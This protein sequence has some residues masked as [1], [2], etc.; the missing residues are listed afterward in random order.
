MKTA[1]GMDVHAKFCSAY[2]VYAGMGETRERHEKFLD[3]FNKE[4]WKFPADG[5]GMKKMAAFLSKHECH[6]L[7][8]NSTKSHEIYWMLKGLGMNVTVAQAVDL[9][10]ITRSVKKTDRNDSIELAAYM[11][12]RL[13]GENEFAACF[14]PSPEWM[15]KRE[16]CRGVYN[17]R[18]YLKEARQRIRAHLLLHG[19]SLSKEYDD[20]LSVKAVREMQEHKDPYLLMQIK[21]ALDAKSRVRFV[22]KAIAQMFSGNRM[23]ELILSIPGVGIVPAAYLTSLIVDIGRFGKVTQFTASFGVVPGKR[24]SADH[25]P[26]CPTT[27]RGDEV[28][29][30]M[31][32]RCAFSHIQNVEDSVVTEMYRRL[33]KRGKVKNEALT[34]ASRKLL[35]VIWSV[36]KKNAPYTVDPE[37]LKRARETEDAE[38][39]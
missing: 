29:R 10:R 16:M 2:A 20:I 6:V 1:I 38:E 9:Y 34:A 19:I 4:F 3:S 36:L 28:A 7:I 25:S 18:I 33:V 27:H 22:E 5:D 32:K 37:L 11:R 12:R 13:N 15:T 21:F 14:I 24:D 17:E 23:Y 30:V 8:E 39:D 31:L 35:T 26:D